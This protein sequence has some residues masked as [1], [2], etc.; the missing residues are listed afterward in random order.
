MYSVHTK[1]IYMY[2][3]P[4]RLSQIHVVASK[5]VDDSMLSQGDQLTRREREEREREGGGG[6]R[7]RVRVRERDRGRE[8]GLSTVTC[9]CTC[10]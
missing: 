9:T 10:R 5:L 3:P 8:R 4:D 7:K 1:H 6:G 2:V